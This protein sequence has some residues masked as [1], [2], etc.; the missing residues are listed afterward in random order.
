MRHSLHSIISTIVLGMLLGLLFRGSYA[1]A[2]QQ[3]TEPSCFYASPSTSTQIESLLSTRHPEI[4]DDGRSSG[5]ERLQGVAFQLQ[6]TQAQADAAQELWRRQQDSQNQDYHKWLTPAEYA[7]I[8]GLPTSGVETVKGWLVSEGLTNVHVN[9][10]RTTIYADGNAARLEQLLATAIHRYSTNNDTFLASA[11]TPTIPTEIRPFVESMKCLGHLRLAPQVALRGSMPLQTDWD[12]PFSQ[13]H[14]VTPGDLKRI[15]NIG[16]LTL[17]GDTGKGQTIAVVVQSAIDLSDVARF[18]SAAGVEA[19]NPTLVLV[20]GTG[21][22]MK[23]SGD[24]LEADIDIE[25]AGAIAPEADT[26]YVYTGSSSEHNVFDALAYAVDQ[27]IAPIV[28]ISYG[29][30]EADLSSDEITS[31]QRVLLQ[32]NLQGQTVVA[33]SGDLG[34]T[35]C[36]TKASQTRGVALNGLAVQ[37]PASSQYVT[38]VGGTMLDDVDGASSFWATQNASDDS[39]ASSYIPER[40]WNETDE[41]GITM[42]LGGGGGASRLFVK[43]AW[44]S[45]PGV[46]SDGARDVPDLAVDAGVYH[47]GYL[48]C[49]SDQVTGVQ[50]S[51]LNGFL[52][53]NSKLTVA[54]GT[55]FGAP[56]VAGIV[57]ILEQSSALGRLGNINSRLY[58]LASQRAAVFHDVTAGDNQQPCASNSKDCPSDGFVGYSAGPGYDQV[59]GLGTP[60]VGELALALSGNDSPLPVSMSLRQVEG[61]IYVGTEASILATLA[62]PYNLLQGNIQFA[63]D[64]NASGAPLTVMDGQATFKFTSLSAGMHELSALFS[65]ASGDLQVQSILSVQVSTSLAQ[66]TLGIKLGIVPATEPNG[67]NTA[68]NVVVVPL[69]NYSG[70]VRF[71]V[72]ASDPLLIQYGCYSIRNV[73]VPADVPVET[74]LVVGRSVEACAQMS[75]QGGSPQKLQDLSVN[76]NSAAQR[77]LLS[78]RLEAKPNGI[79][80]VAET[81]GLFVICWMGSGWKKR[82]ASAMVLVTLIGGLLGCSVNVESVQSAPSGSYTL[83]VSAADAVKPSIWSSSSAVLYIE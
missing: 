50:N 70:Q 62:G 28:S 53:A 47:D 57:S 59:T 54:G 73:D 3:R 40:A 67:T 48:L 78:Q 24:E 61:T 38:A 80:G 5:N 81:C 34:A 9:A 56:I 11:D 33:E 66:S 46:P 12:S 14:Y 10:S 58:T 41:A 4:V 68:A 21:I 15:Y 8:F 75:S 20:P 25:Y 30:C 35:G 45:S 51:C 32:A 65:S 74:A 37:Y 71:T 55:S 60:N 82:V 72:G 6:Q 63:I 49:S 29:E 18:R 43:P 13:E 44:Q 1:S 83:Q 69:N 52:G 39:S 64:G 27:N 22:A 16:P 23:R 79:T 2:Q 26:I 77:S 42:L 19:R 76:A 7:D 17:K 31:M 36:E